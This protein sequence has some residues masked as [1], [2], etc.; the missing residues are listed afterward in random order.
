MWEA[1]RSRGTLFYHVPEVYWW[2]PNITEGRKEKKSLSQNLSEGWFLVT[3]PYKNMNGH[4]SIFTF[5]SSTFFSHRHSLFNAEIFQLSDYFNQSY[6]EKPQFVQRKKNFF[7]FLWI[8][9]ELQCGDFFS[10]SS[11]NNLNYPHSLNY[12]YMGQ[13]IK[14]LW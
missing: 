2:K 1:G 5:L 4:N 13:K 6:S 8:T 11:Y 7:S 12:Q 9:S 3:S 10:Y 14:K